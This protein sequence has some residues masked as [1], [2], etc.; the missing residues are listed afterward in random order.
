MNKLRIMGGVSGIMEE[1]HK[2]LSDSTVDNDI[3]DSCNEED[4]EIHNDSATSSSMMSILERLKSHTP[5]D[6][7]RKRKVRKNP[8]VGKKRLVE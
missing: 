2:S 5:S 8:P 6:F 1:E 4:H 3:D 7:A